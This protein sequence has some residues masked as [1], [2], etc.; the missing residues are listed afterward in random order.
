MTTLGFGVARAQPLMAARF[1][2][3][4][5]LATRSC[6]VTIAPTPTA[7]YGE[8]ARALVERQL[9]IAWLP[10]IAALEL[11]ERGAVEV[12]ALPL[13]S[14]AMAYHTALV[15]KSGAAK[16]LSRYRGGRVAWVDPHSAS[17]YVMPRVHLASLGVDPRAFF[18][19][20]LFA[21]THLGVVD[22]VASGR[23]DLG[24]TYCSC[25]GPA[26]RVVRGAWTSPEGAPIRPVEA[27]VTAG[28][29][30]NDA[31]VVTPD[32]GVLERASLMRFLMTPTP[33]A[34]AL[35][36]D[37]FNTTEFRVAK[38]NHFAQLREMVRT[39]RSL[40][41]GSIVPAPFRD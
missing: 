3:L 7:T 6:G 27:I 33:D 16:D 14:G 24:A 18:G 37:T 25:E 5:L 40:G 32:V 26:R 34:R 19:Q 8:L 11:S 39:A 17:G 22:A 21:Q 2:E 23:A 1:S 9:A 31:I 15:A 30:P 38:P 41:Y 29:I 4:C 13:R 20:E 12:L 35:L 28:P 36:S 10:P